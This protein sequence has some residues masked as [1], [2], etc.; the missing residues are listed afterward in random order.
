[1]L[2]P[3]AAAR[4]S[5]VATLSVAVA[6]GCGPSS[7]EVKRAR[8]IAYR[9]GFAAV[10]DAAVAVMNEKVP[11]VELADRDHGIVVSAFRWHSSS[12]MA[13]KR[14]AAVVRDGDVGLVV[15]LALAR[16]P[17]GYRI[18]A[19]PH[20]FEQDISSPRG[21][22]LSHDDADWPPWADGK[23]DDILIAIHDRLAGCPVPRTGADEPPPPAPGS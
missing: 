12:G 3:A 4:L 11:P 17:D 9:C 23:T 6:A 13:R 10:F 16:Q 15:E 1:V 5:V 22:E 14:G 19:A 7:A 21:R 2:S 8:D 18:R 20:I